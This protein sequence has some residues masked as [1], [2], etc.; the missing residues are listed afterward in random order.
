MDISESGPYYTIN[1]CI[2]GVEATARANLETAAVPISDRETGGSRTVFLNGLEV[3]NS[4]TGEEI[5]VTPRV[6]SLVLEAL[7][8]EQEPNETPI[9]ATEEE[10]RASGVGPITV[11]RENDDL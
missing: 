9:A 1:L 11:C 3:T 7:R 2:D 10:A 5:A 6:R 8:A 4:A